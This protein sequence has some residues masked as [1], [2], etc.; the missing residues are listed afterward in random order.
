MRAAD[1]LAGTR[2]LVAPTQHV[3]AG[4]KDI[5]QPHWFRFFLQCHIQAICLIGEEVPALELLAGTRVLV[6]PGQ[7]VPADGVVVSGA[8]AADESMLTGEAAPVEKV[9]GDEVLGGTVNASDA[10]LEVR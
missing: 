6:A 8:S 1:L 7:R 9:A 5:T 2:V 4:G 3:P 10:P